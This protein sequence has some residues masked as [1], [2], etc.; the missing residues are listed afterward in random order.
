MGAGV[1]LGDGDDLVADDA[2]GADAPVVAAAGGVVVD[3]GAEEPGDV[4]DLGASPVVGGAG[5]QLDGRAG[6]RDRDGGV[7]VEVVGELAQGADEFALA[8]RG[9][10]CSAS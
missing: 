8:R 9:R 3:V 2:E 7:P 5:V 6:F 4:V 10:W 1:V